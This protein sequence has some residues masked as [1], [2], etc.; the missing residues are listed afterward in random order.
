MTKQLKRLPNDRVIWGICAGLA[1][2]LGWDKTLV[3]I[4]MVLIFCLTSFFPITV[5]Y[6][7]AY[8]IMPVEKTPNSNDF[9]R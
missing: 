8:F 3:R 7:V 9:I 2:Y 1:Q 4:L 6:I 5:L